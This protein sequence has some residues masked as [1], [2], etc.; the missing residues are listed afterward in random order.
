MESSEVFVKEEMDEAG[1][2]SRNP[3][4]R[5]RPAYKVI[6]KKLSYLYIGFQK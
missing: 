5:K 4:N 3:Q 6:Q 1:Q 2:C